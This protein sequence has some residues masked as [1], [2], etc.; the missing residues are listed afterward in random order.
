MQAT[1]TRRAVDNGFDLAK[2]DKQLQDF[3]KRDGDMEVIPPDH[4]GTYNMGGGGYREVMVD[5]DD[6]AA[7]N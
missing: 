4:H 1:R 7:H 2:I 6:V 5:D 3:V